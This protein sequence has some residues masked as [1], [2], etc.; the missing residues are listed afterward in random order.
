MMTI[1]VL[2]KIVLIA[3]YSQSRDVHTMLLI[4]RVV[5]HFTRTKLKIVVITIL[6]LKYLYS[7]NYPPILFKSITYFN[8]ITP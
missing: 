7:V 5:S 8:S 3:L 1:D 6:Y 4:Q 2:S